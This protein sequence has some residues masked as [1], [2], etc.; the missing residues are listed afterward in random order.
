M[1][2]NKSIYVAKVKTKY[3][4]MVCLTEA[5]LQVEVASVYCDNVHLKN[6]NVEL[7]KYVLLTCEQRSIEQINYTNVMVAKK[8]K[9]KITPGQIHI[10]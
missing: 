6:I 2:R 3:F 4:I 9:S 5:W 1:K 10:E 8:F 7:H